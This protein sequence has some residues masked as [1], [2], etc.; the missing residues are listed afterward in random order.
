MLARVRRF[1][2]RWKNALIHGADIVDVTNAIGNSGR[3]IGRV[4]AWGCTGR[5]YTNGDTVPHL[6]NRST[7]SVQTMEGFFVNVAQSVIASWSQKPA[8]D[9]VADSWGRFGTPKA[10]KVLRGR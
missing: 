7:Y 6:R 4:K 10:R 8:M 2:V 5:R 9:T 1:A 3:R